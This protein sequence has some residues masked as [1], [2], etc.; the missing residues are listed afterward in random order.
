MYAVGGEVKIDSSKEQDPA[1]TIRKMAQVRQAALAPTTPSA[2]DRQVAA[3]ATQIE[4]QARTELARQ[5]QDTPAS[6]GSNQNATLLPGFQQG[7]Y[8]NSPQTNPSP[9]NLDI[10]S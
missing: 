1:A 10:W 6:L 9:Q 4:N 2:T 3:Q 7:P 8:A 5:S